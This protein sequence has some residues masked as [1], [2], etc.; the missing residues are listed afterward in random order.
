MQTN[1]KLWKYRKLK[2]HYRDKNFS[3]NPLF[4]DDITTVVKKLPSNKASISITKNF[5]I[6]CC[7]KITVIKIL[8]L[9]Q[10]KWVP[11]F[12]EIAESSPVL[13]SLTTL[14]R[15]TISLNNLSSVN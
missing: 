13:R 4:I 1:F 5:P 15:V 10:R 11:E 8:W 7:D 9:S 12:N 6:C 2:E 3:F 14:W